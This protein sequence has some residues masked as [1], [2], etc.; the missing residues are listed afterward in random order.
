MN[1][2]NAINPAIAPMMPSSASLMRK[3][4]LD[5]SGLPEGSLN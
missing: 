1:I 4:R 5:G 3:M 2:R